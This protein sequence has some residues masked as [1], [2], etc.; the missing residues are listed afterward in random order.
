MTGNT[1]PGIGS[2]RQGFGYGAEHMGAHTNRPIM[3]CFALVAAV[4][5]IGACSDGIDISDGVGT[6]DECAA[7]ARVVNS[8]VSTEAIVGHFAP[9]M[10]SPDSAFWDPV[11][12]RC[13]ISGLPA[14]HGEHPV[15]STS[16]CEAH[17]GYHNRLP[18]SGA[19][20]EFCLIE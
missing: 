5:L 6:P 15:I 11:G 18:S 8:R 19:E 3:R 4:L 10:G 17:G 9:V 12:G 2:Q 7:V 13:M 14:S 1:S 20:P 16:Q